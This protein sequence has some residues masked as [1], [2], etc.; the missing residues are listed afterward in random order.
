MDTNDLLNEEDKK[1]NKKDKKRFS[2]KKI[3]KLYIGLGLLGIV[4]LGVLGYFLFFTGVPPTERLP[5][6]VGAATGARVPGRPEFTCYDHNRRVR[7]SRCH[8]STNDPAG[9]VH[10]YRWTTTTTAIPNS[11]TRRIASTRAG[12]PTPNNPQ[13]LNAGADTVT[14]ARDRRA[15]VQ[16]KA[17]NNFGNCGPWSNIQ[18]IDVDTNYGR[19]STG[20]TPEP[21]RRA[22]VAGDRTAPTLRS[23]NVTRNRTF[24]DHRLRFEDPSGIRSIT[25]EPAVTGQ[26]IEISRTGTTGEV[27]IPVYWQNHSDNPLRVTI[28]VTD[29]AGNRQTITRN[30]R[31]PDQVRDGKTTF[32]A[33]TNRFYVPARQICRTGTHPN[34]SGVSGSRGRG[35]QGSHVVFGWRM[36]NFMRD[37][38]DAGHGLRIRE[39]G[40]TTS[41]FRPLQRQQQL[42]NNPGNA[43]A[44][45]SMHGWGVAV[46][47]QF[48]R[49][50]GNRNN[51][52]DWSMCSSP[53]NRRLFSCNRSA[54]WAHEN[55]ARYGLVFNMGPG[56]TIVEPWHA[57]ARTPNGCGRSGLRPVRCGNVTSTTAR[58]CPTIRGQSN[59]C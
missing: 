32:N 53:E 9:V 29:N 24:H 22:P 21:S 4:M 36:Q 39:Q 3:K 12:D 56:S 26:R 23:E 28:R 27:L 8:M 40:T 49:D 57:E 55:A 11:T 1:P 5:Q 35:I 31:G 59:L 20:F 52:N 19:R 58:N 37:A 33:R 51:S 17:C 10:H 41:V 47:F 50:G 46:D 30:L 15:R 14:F 6:L 45:L 16:V 25:V 34:C 48:L 13:R 43:A 54:R 42:Q 2:F 18:I 44:G 38:T 7:A